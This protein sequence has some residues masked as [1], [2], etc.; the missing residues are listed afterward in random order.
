MS[1]RR[2]RGLFLSIYVDDIKM[3]RRKLNFRFHAEEMNEICWSWR[4][5]IISWPRILEMHSTWMQTE[6]ESL[7]TNTEKCSNHEFLLEQLRHCQGGGNL[8]QK[9]SRRSTKCKDTRK[10]A[11][12]GTP[13][14][15]IKDRAIV[16]SLSS[17]LRWPSLQEGTGISWIIVKCVLSDC[18][19]V[20]VS[21]KNW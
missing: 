14:W 9:L 1:V 8:T 15:Q 3:S 13:N 18:H 19:E 11:L 4:I 20:L 6:R 2:K 10:S 12:R 17:L 16:Q 5:S 7:L 21:D